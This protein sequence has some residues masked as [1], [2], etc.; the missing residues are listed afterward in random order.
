MLISRL[1]QNIKSTFKDFVLVHISSTMMWIHERARW[2][3]ESGLSPQSP[4]ERLHLL[5]SSQQ[6]PVTYYYILRICKLKQLDGVF[7]W[8][9]TNHRRHDTFLIFLMNVML[10]KEEGLMTGC[11]ELFSTRRLG[12]FSL[13]CSVWRH[14]SANL[15]QLSHRLRAVLSWSQPL[16]KTQFASVYT[17]VGNKKQVLQWRES[18]FH[19]L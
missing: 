2:F 4:A 15:S 11:N 13:H 6:A 1:K 10:Q 3:Y 16:E 7:W 14:S 12:G 18:W 9:N 19:Q 5:L 17:H 8:K